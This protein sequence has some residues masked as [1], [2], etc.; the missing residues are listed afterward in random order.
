MSKDLFSRY[1]WLVD[2]IRRHGRITRSE[3]NRLWIQA[4]FSGGRPLARRSFFNYR[5]GIQQVFD[6]TVMCDTSTFEYY[7]EENDEYDSSVTNWVLNS[8]SISNML[9]ASRDISGRIFLEQ[10]PSAR[11]HLDKVVE[12]LRRNVRIKFDYSPYYRSQTTHG[13]VLEPYFLK[14]FRQRWYITG[15]NV[16]DGKIKTYALDRMAAVNLTTENFSLPADFDPESFS[17]DAFGIIFSQ[18]EVHNIVIRADLR[19]AKYLRTLPLHHSQQEM[20]HDTFS[21]FHY[22]MRITPDFV[23]E[24][25]SFGPSVT[26]ISPPEL[27]AMIV[28]SLKA[29]LTNYE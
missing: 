1:I 8:T 24:L 3:L 15:L 23:R 25:L 6:I 17:R 4:P 28:E 9:T 10:I 5:E 22:R 19:Q 20:L 16:R 2:T 12:S 11:L 21:D 13:I 27:K 14:I 26:V 29:T 18:W 7:I